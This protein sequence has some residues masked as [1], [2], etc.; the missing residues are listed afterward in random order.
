MIG[1]RVDHPEADV[2]AFEVHPIGWVRRA[3]YLK[4]GD[5]PRQGRFAPAATSEIEILD[6]YRDGLGCLEGISHVHVLLW[7][8]QARRDTLLAHPPHLGGETLP[9][10]CT[11]SPSRP[12]PIGLNLAEVLSVRDGVITVA[13]M[14]AFEGTAIL[15]IKP[16]IPSIDCVPDATDMLAPGAP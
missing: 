8:D 2:S 15:D 5:A 16:Y 4:R 3:P 14:D 11:R 13:G 9:V 10:F 12:N 6:R 7:Y 1:A